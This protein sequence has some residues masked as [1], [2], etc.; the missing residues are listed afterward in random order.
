M[1]PVYALLIEI[2]WLKNIHT[3]TDLL[4]VGI[5]GSRK[6]TDVYKISEGVSARVLRCVALCSTPLR[7]QGVSP[8]IC[9][10]TRCHS[11]T[12]EN[13]IFKNPIER[14]LYSYLTY[15][16]LCVLDCFSQVFVFRAL[17]QVS[18][19]KC[20][21]THKGLKKGGILRRFSCSEILR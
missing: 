19:A 1:L 9:H 6:F 7:T 21:F 2:S 10:H 8:H 5:G 16:I 3:P 17:D 12:C 20:S 11:H 14:Y 15:C 18:A 4:D 13:L